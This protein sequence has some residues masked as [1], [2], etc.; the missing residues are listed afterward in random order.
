[1]YTPYTDG[2]KA[3]GSRKCYDRSLSTRQVGLSHQQMLRKKQPYAAFNASKCPYT[4]Q[5][6]SHFRS[7]TE[8]RR[9]RMPHRSCHRSRQSSHSACWRGCKTGE[10]TWN[11]QKDFRLLLHITYHTK[12]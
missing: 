7:R 3:T 4:H 5:C 11:R 1:M 9:R 8:C 10:R 6:R 2:R 12:M